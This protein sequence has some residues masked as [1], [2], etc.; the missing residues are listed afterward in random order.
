MFY[1]GDCWWLQSLDGAGPGGHSK[2]QQLSEAVCAESLFHCVRLTGKALII[3]GLVS[4]RTTT[5]AQKMR[6]YIEFMSSLTSK[7]TKRSCFSPKT[8]QCQSE[9]KKSQTEA[10]MAFYS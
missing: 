4:L 3:K 7:T 5:V 8:S 10:S 6:D 9:G 1:P 2:F